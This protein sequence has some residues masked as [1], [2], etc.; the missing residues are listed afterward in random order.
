MNTRT[1]P[2]KTDYRIVMIGPHGE[3]DYLERF[4][5]IGI[6]INCGNSAEHAGIFS[7]KCAA[8]AKRRLEIYWMAEGESVVIEPV[9]G[10]A[11]MVQA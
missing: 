5:G 7:E 10:S 9:G 11:E 2:T 1:S 8:R 3:R 6:P 4:D